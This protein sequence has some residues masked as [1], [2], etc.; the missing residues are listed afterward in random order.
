M[1]RDLTRRN[2]TLTLILSLSRTLT[3]YNCQVIQPWREIYEARRSRRGSR[4]GSVASQKS[5]PRLSTED[6]IGSISEQAPGAAPRL[7]VQL[8]ALELG[9]ESSEELQHSS[10]ASR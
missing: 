6:S 4:A 2:L 10:P 3:A 7:S 5:Q 8:D 1:A 9:R